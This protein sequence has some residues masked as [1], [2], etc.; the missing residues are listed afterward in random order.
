MRHRWRSLL[1]SFVAA[2]LVA[3]QPA[4]AQDDAERAAQQAALGLAGLTVEQVEAQPANP[5]W[6]GLGLFSADV[7][8]LLGAAGA[9]PLEV[10]EY[11]FGDDKT[12]P[13]I[14]EPGGAR[15]VAHGQATLTLPEG[16]AAPATGFGD[17]MAFAPA[18]G[19]AVAPGDEILLLWT[20]FDSPYD[21]SDRSLTINE[22][23]PLTVPGLPVWNSTFAGD[24]W[25]G[26]NLIPNAVWDGANLSFDVKSF[27]PPQSFPLVD[28]PGFYYR[29]G[30]VMAMALHADT[31]R[32]Y[33]DAAAPA[34]AQPAAESD[35]APQT[36]L[37]TGGAETITTQD[38]DAFGEMLIRFYTHVALQLFSP[39]FIALSVVAQVIVLVDLIV[40]AELIDTWILLES[41]PE[42]DPEPA[43]EPTAPPAD[44]DPDPAAEQTQDQAD[45]DEEQQ[46]QQEEVAQDETDPV[47]DAIDRAA[48]DDGANVWL[49]IIPLLVV[50]LLGGAWLWRRSRPANHVG[51]T[52]VREEKE[53]LHTT[54]PGPPVH[55]D[56]R[57]ERDWEV[58]FHGDTQTVHLRKAE[59]GKDVV[60]TV[61]VKVDSKIGYHAQVASFRQDIRPERQY[62]PDID[63][64]F[65]GIGYDHNAS[66]RSGPAGRQDWQ[67]GDGDPIDQSALDDGA[68]FWQGHQG[69]EPPEVVAHVEHDEA[70]RVRVWVEGECADGG[71]IFDATSDGQ[72]TTL[73]TGETTDDA[74]RESSPIELTAMGFHWGFV[75]GDLGYSFQ[76]ESGSDIDEL[77]RFGEEVAGEDDFEPPRPSRELINPGRWDAIVHGT[78]L[79]TPTREQT[80]GGSANARKTGNRF[81]TRFDT[82]SLCDAAQSVPEAVYATTERVSSHSDARFAYNLSVR[83]T[84][85]S[86]P[87]APSVDVRIDQER[88]QVAVD[89]LFHYFHRPEMGERNR[90]P[91]TPTGWRRWE[92]T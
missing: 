47:G 28:I 55:T 44:P 36:L 61:H 20:Q 84:I 4:A 53:D 52:R 77:E 37:Y 75:S 2:L 70:T 40:A 24:T 60:C 9:G 33:I 23:F 51:G 5:S 56:D 30:D 86:L 92:L 78:P 46:Q 8:R 68:G 38:D 13:P 63:F 34:S 15:P 17:T 14:I 32:A 66:T 74:P 7:T 25:E 45:V 90:P 91:S 6:D 16:W 1:I 57:P 54:P 65:Q 76:T 22:G 81:F 69:D 48:G 64:A 43:P 18:A 12:V 85:P 72:V 79:E 11:A 21:F 42:P 39:G 71:N 49:F 73:L 89:G 59:A 31:L 27:A 19:G 58:I 26:A 3:P 83:V 88:T 82:W 87:G 67:H 35:A 10:E 50:G 41:V 62:I 29:S 80:F